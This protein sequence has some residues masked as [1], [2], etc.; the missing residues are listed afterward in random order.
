[1]TAA[2]G[3]GRRLIL[4]ARTLQSRPPGG[5][6]RTVR[7][8]LPH[9][10]A[11]LDSVAL[12]TDARLPPPEGV[13]AG[14]EVYALRAP[15]PTGTAWLQLA[16]P[17]RLAGAAEGTVFHC[18]FY[19][20]PFR[21]P[22]PGVVS[23]YDLTFLDHPEWFRALPRRAFRAQARHA[24]RTAGAVITGSETVA[25]LVAERLGVDRS[26]IVVAPPAVDD[27][28]RRARPGTPGPR[29]YVVALGGAPRRHLRVAVAAWRHAIR[30]GAEVDLVVVGTEPPP[31]P[32]DPHLR[33]AGVVDDSRL[34]ELWAGA[35][36]FVYPTRYE[37]F[38]LPAAEAAAC[39][40]AVVCARV[41]ALPEVLGP[42]ARW[43]DRPGA[44]ALA[45]GIA[46]LAGD[47]ARGAQL[48]ALGRERFCSGP[49]WDVMAAGW[50]DAYR[51][52]RPA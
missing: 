13:P 12:L 10:V 42:A 3:P 16:A 48:G 26:R 2:R 22:V 45:E 1:M 39:G 35:V 23:L 34:A 25:A 27:V 32:P 15:L 4:D 7:G 19:G 21:L 44:E 36:A 29:P 6:G 47:A 43:C 20:L 17:R 9:L 11:S 8:A 50:L 33:Y 46:E 37:G 30:Q 5:I 24:A 18:P 14:A 41:G 28:F 31:G 40:T 52:A 49:G 38:G 51:L